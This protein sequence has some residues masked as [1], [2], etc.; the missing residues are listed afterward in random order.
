MN[1]Y[2]EILIKVEWVT[3]IIL[4][5][6]S[7]LFEWTLHISFREHTSFHEMSSSIFL[8]NFMAFK[9]L[10]GY[11]HIMTPYRYQ[12]LHSGLNLHALQ[13][14]RTAKFAV[15]LENVSHAKKVGV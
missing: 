9:K 13:H 6:L 4:K 2:W 10:Y 11:R 12:T 15:K 7:W 1:V 14:H 8:R 5:N 3:A